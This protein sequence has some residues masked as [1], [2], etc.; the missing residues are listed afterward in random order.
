M[1]ADLDGSN[2]EVVADTA[3][4]PL[5]ITIDSGSARIYFITYNNTALFRVNTDGTGMETLATLAGQGVGVAFD[6]AAQKVYYSTRANDIFVSDADGSNQAVLITGQGAVQ[7]LAID[8]DE[9]SIYWSA[10]IAGMIRKADLADGANI[11]D[12]AASQ[13]NAWHVALGK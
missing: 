3:T 2:S 11:E 9:G 1:R 13:G 12:F 6:S 4:S 5:G 10:P 8:T 7:G